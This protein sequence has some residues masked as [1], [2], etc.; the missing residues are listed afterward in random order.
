M[1]SVPAMTGWTLDRAAFTIQ[2]DGGPTIYPTR[3]E[4]IVLRMMAERPGQLCLREA[5]F[6]YVPALGARDTLMQAVDS[7]I[8]R[9]R[10][11]GVDAIRTRYGFG[12]YWDATVPIRVIN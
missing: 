9:L 12:Y 5:V 6:E 1:T 11:K 10:K 7:Y 2:K 8:K 4:F 3:S